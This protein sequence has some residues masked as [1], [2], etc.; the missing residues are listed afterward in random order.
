MLQLIAHQRREP[1][2]AALAP[3]QKPRLLNLSPFVLSPCTE[4]A[5]EVTAA[6][7]AAGC[8]SGR[9]SCDSGSCRCARP[10]AR[11][12]RLFGGTRT[13]VDPVVDMRAMLDGQGSKAGLKQLIGERR[14]ADLG[15][16]DGWLA[17]T[18]GRAGCVGP[19]TCGLVE[20]A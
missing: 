6:S 11:G 1:H 3:V 15:L 7:V 20:G 9:G 13:D 4:H 5:V 8:G 10:C 17:A 12:R 18:A 19:C 16:N 14:A 2:T